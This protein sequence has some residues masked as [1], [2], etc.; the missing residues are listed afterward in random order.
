MNHISTISVSI[1]GI[2]YQ[3]NLNEIDKFEQKSQSDILS[4]VYEWPTKDQSHDSKFY[5]LKQSFL[6]PSEI[7]LYTI[8]TE[9]IQKYYIFFLSAGET[10]KTSKL[11]SFE[12]ATLL[13]V[14]LMIA[15]T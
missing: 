14:F 13:L 11:L 12:K 5:F 10:S 9:H 2:K 8:N 15:A 1:S 6:F 7:Y 3:S 4:K